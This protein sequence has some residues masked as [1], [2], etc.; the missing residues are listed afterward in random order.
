MGDSSTN[1]FSSSEAVVTGCSSPIE[2]RFKALWEAKK[3]SPV[4][5]YHD[6][7]IDKGN[8]SRIRRGLIVPPKYLRIQIASY[9]GVDSTT[10]W[11]IDYKKWCD[12]NDAVEGFWDKVEEVKK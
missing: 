7:N 8:A 4:Q 12:L 3:Q 1:S 11:D 10:I 2:A 9:F 6:L 5:W